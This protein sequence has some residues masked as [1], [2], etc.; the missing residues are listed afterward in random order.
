VEHSGGQLLPRFPFRISTGITCGVKA[1]N[2]CRESGPGIKSLRGDYASPIFDNGWISQRQLSAFELKGI[3]IFVNTWLQ[4]LSIEVTITLCA[5][6]LGFLYFV[7]HLLVGH[8]R[9]EKSRAF[10]KPDWKILVGG[11]SIAQD[12]SYPLIYGTSTTD[13]GPWIGLIPIYLGN[14]GR[15]SFSDVY[16]QFRYRDEQGICIP[17]DNLYIEWS[18]GDKRLHHRESQYESVTYHVKHL[19]PGTRLQVPEPIV[20]PATTVVTTRVEAET[21]DNVLLYADVGAFILISVEVVISAKDE[22]PFVFRLNIGAIQAPS[23]NHLTERYR[24]ILEYHKS[25]QPLR[26][27]L[28]KV[29]FKFGWRGN[30]S[31]SFIVFCNSG[32]PL[33]SGRELAID[34]WDLRIRKF[35]SHR[36]TKKI[37]LTAAEGETKES[38]FGTSS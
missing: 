1:L 22:K 3:N 30:P 5:I 19:N 14:V 18:F 2:Q 21:K 13:K 24:Q 27:I 23:A 36:G 4:N 17:S 31:T 26:S 38:F 35:V 11:F 15:R 37:E 6:L 28:A 16:V 10:D 7:I 9:A 8:R 29:A 12:Q 32:L 33:L 20:L 25:K 34:K